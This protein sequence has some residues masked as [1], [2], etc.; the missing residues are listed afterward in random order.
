METNNI[1]EIKFKLKTKVIKCEPI[2][3]KYRYAKRIGQKEYKFCK[4]LIWKEWVNEW[5]QELVDD[6]E[7]YYA[8]EKTDA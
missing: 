8:A 4:N 6:I 7:A 5:N 2:L 1:P 3:M